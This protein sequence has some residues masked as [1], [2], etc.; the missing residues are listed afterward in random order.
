MRGLALVPSRCDE[1][2]LVKGKFE[3][4]SAHRG[5]E[6]QQGLVANQGVS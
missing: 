2:R 1:G 4:G 6:G 3:M 5:I